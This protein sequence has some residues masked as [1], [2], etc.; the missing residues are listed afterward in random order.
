MIALLKMKIA[1]N[2][3]FFVLIVG[4]A[5]ALGCTTDHDCALNGDCVAGKCLCDAA[6][7]GSPECDVMAF[8]KSKHVKSAMPGY[9]NHTERSVSNLAS[10]FA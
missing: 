7:A 5:A 4:I 1:S 10:L 8:D 2:A 6:W 9:Y 3:A